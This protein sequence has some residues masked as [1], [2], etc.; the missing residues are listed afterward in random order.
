MTREQAK[1]CL[2]AAV[3]ACYYGATRRPRLSWVIRQHGV[4]LKTAEDFIS[5]A[6]KS[7]LLQD[8]SYGWISATP[9]LCSIAAQ[10]EELAAD[11]EAWQDDAHTP[12]EGSR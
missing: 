12:R 8:N 5:E 1:A 9:F 3:R 10:F 6:L 2:E 7:K 4:D 11:V